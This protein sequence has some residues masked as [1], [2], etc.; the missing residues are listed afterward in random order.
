MAVS[1]RELRLG[2]LVLDMAVSCLELR[3][4]SLVSSA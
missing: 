4:G 1:C 2:S 3:H